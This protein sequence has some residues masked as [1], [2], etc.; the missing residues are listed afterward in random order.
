MQ[1]V[2]LLVHLCEI[3]IIGLKDKSLDASG[4]LLSLVAIAESFTRH[5]N[6][7]ATT[8]W[9]SGV[10]EKCKD[11]SLLHRAKYC[12]RA[13]YASSLAYIKYSIFQRWNERFVL[14]SRCF[15]E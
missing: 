14:F 6:F 10:A 15:N 9:C 7:G 13:G 5:M 11:V 4:Q 8:L 12:R 2:L 3:T 1:T